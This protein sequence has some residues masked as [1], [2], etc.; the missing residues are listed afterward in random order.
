MKLPVSVQHLTVLN[1]STVCLNRNQNL[2]RMGHH[3]KPFSPWFSPP[4]LESW[5]ETPAFLSWRAVRLD[6]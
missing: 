1:G 3:V 6:V 2:D 4:P 5:A